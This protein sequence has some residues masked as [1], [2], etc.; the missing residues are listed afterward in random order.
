[1]SNGAPEERNVY[2]KIFCTPASSS[3]A[4]FI[5][6]NTYTQIYIHVVFA[7]Q[8]RQCLISRERKEELQKYITGIV[9]RQG[10]K[11]I[12]ISCMSDH[13]H[14]LI[15]LKPNKALS[16]LVGDMKT[17]STN[18]I[19]EN[20][21]VSGR[22][23]WQEGFGAFSYAHSQLSTVIRYIQNQE[24]HHARKTFREEYVEF[25]DRFEVPFEERY[26]FE[27]I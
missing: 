12:A 2:S 15:G 13:T 23:S 4:S 19:N 26:L 25:L 10:Q 9:T 5:M 1:M 20:R 8:G 16:D 7:V 3:G 11:L 21:W 22:F 18:H 24:K 17:G 6:A 14:A 27:N